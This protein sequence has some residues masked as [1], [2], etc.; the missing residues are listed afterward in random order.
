MAKQHRKRVVQ[1]SINYKSKITFADANAVT[2][3]ADSLVTRPF[4]AARWQ[5]SEVWLRVLEQRGDGPKLTILNPESPPT[6]RLVRYRWSDAVAWMDNRGKPLLPPSP[7]N[8]TPAEKSG[9]MHSQGS[10]RD[11][12]E[13]DLQKIGGLA[14]VGD[15]LAEIEAADEDPM[16]VVNANDGA[17]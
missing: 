6:S 4:L 7:E 15:E 14:A 10:A 12:A 2:L 11:K 17:K 16:E 1:D 3:Q 5:I 13:W 8:M 9:F